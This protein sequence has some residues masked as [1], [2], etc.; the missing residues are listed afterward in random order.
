MSKAYPLG[1]RPSMPSFAW[2]TLDINVAELLR[3]VDAADIPGD[4]YGLGA[5]WNVNA[6]VATLRKSDVDCSGFV[7]WILRQAS[8]EVLSFPDGSWIQHEWVK[9]HGFKASSVEAGKL[10]DHA[11]RIA[12]LSPQDGGGVGH[13]ALIHNGETIESHG[14]AGPDRRPW[15]GLRWQ[16]KC[17][18]YVLVSPIMGDS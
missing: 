3:L 1:V 5:K 14:A 12:F 7:R 18:V 11:V 2:P 16:G 6:D 8:G 13:V 10:V 15:N 9:K 17:R 4:Q